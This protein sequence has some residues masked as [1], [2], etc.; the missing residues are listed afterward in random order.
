MKELELALPVAEHVWLEVGERTNITDG[1]ELLDRLLRFHPSTSALNS[2]VISA[3]IA[4]RAD[5]PSNS[6]RFTVST[7]GMSTPSRA[8]SSRALCAVATPSAT[9]SLPARASSSDFPFP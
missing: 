3:E 6:T 2:L 7:I 9:V 4:L 8:A 5:W 1:K